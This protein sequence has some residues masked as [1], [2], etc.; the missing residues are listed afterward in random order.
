MTRTIANH[1]VSSVINNWNSTQLPDLQG[2][3]I[4]V[5]GAN[6]GIGSH[7]ALQLGPSR[8]FHP[9]RPPTQVN[10]PTR[11]NDQPLARARWEASAQLSG[12]TLELAR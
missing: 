10:L 8:R 6:R 9:K 5:T 4:I 3:T 1:A 2:K 7:T 11:A 12:L